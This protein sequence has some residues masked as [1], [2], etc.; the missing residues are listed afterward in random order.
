MFRKLMPI[1]RQFGS[2]YGD[3][4]IVYAIRLIDIT[5]LHIVRK[6]Y[7]GFYYK[8]MVPSVREILYCSVSLLKA[9]IFKYQFHLYNDALVSLSMKV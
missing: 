5:R 2:S 9:R 7:T 6:T 4:K 1:V 8:M 3:M